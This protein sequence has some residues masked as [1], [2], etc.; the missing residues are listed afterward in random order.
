MIW[1]GWPAGAL[2]VAA[3]AALPPSGLVAVVSLG[4]GSAAQAAA[5][6]LAPAISRAKR[7]EALGGGM[8]SLLRGAWDQILGE[9]PSASESR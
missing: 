5:A 8:E 2:A 3:G 1:R 7:F 6:R 4:A 9:R